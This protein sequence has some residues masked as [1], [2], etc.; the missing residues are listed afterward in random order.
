[1]SDTISRQAAIANAISGLVR[2]ED[3][4]KWIRVSEV[5]ESLLNMPS[6]EPERKTGQWTPDGKGFYKCTS[7]GESWSHWWAVVV[8]PDRMYKELRFCPNCGAWMERSVRNHE[9][10]HH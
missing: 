7:C 4:E 2:I 9:E 5:R 1:M 8:S 10:E 3:G 6:V